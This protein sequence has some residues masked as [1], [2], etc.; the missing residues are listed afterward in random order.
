MIV[1]TH[2]YLKIAIFWDIQYSAPFSRSKNETYV[3][4]EDGGDTFLGNVGS[5]TDYTAL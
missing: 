4:Q 3:Q 5:Y 2:Y 1:R